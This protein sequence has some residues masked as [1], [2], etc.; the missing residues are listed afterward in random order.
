MTRRPVS[1]IRISRADAI[2]LFSYALAC[3]G[4]DAR[5]PRKGT[6]MNAPDLNALRPEQRAR[7]LAIEASGLTHPGIRLFQETLGFP[8]TCR[9]RNCRRAKACVGAKFYCVRDN[10]ALLVNEVLPAMRGER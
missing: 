3:G 4:D 2:S 7:L 10:R 1:F 8:E 5:A 6:H 9:S